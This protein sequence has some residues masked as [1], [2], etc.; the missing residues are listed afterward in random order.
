MTTT[1]TPDV[2]DLEQLVIE[3]TKLAESEEQIKERRATIRATLARH[4]DVGTTTLAGHKIVVTQPSRLDPKA[5]TLA[6]PVAQHPEM[7][8]PKISTTAVREHVAPVDLA[9]YTTTG[10]RTVTIR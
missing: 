8:E 2:V 6:F 9:Q 3:D 10:A 1:K 5:L 4:L 7:Y